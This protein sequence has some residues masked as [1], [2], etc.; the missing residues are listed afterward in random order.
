MS[1]VEPRYIKYGYWVNHAHGP[2]MGQ[3]ITTDTNSG[4]IIIALLAILSSLGLGHLFNLF[5]FLIYQRRE[6]GSHEHRDGLFRQQQALLRTLPTPGSLLIAVTKLWL[7][8]R[9]RAKR[10]LRRSIV[11]LVFALISVIGIP[12]AGVFSSSVIT[13]INLEVLVDSPFCANIDQTTN[14]TFLK[15]VYEGI[16][17]SLALSYSNDCYKDSPLSSTRCG[18]F[19][20]PKIKFNTTNTTCPFSEPACDSPAITF[21]SGLVDLNS[22][23]GL[24]LAEKDQVHYRRKVTCALLSSAGRVKHLT[25]SEV[26]SYVRLNPPF[27]DEE[28]LIYAMGYRP[29]TGELYNVTF[30]QSLTESNTSFRFDMK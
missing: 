15:G 2:V 7:A 20:T 27:P 8:W 25:A 1:E 23:F 30:L 13:N 18:V 17:D 16:V 10:P 3:T 4:T 9:R 26:P 22:A 28:F 6:H 19:V 14:E 21:D 29:G 11:L 24:N 5:T 12:L